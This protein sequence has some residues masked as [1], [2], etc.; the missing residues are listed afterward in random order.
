M[1]I[2]YLDPGNI[3]SDLQSGATAKY[4]VC[5]S[6]LDFLFVSSLVNLVKII[7]FTYLKNHSYSCIDCWM[8][9]YSYS[10]AIET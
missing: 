1:S 7:I 2:A 5:F 6:V 10:I 8:I 9:F 4:D 3:E